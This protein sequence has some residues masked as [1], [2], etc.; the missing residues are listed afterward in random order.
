LKVGLGKF[1][2]KGT[3]SL[4][5]FCCFRQLVVIGSP[6]MPEFEPQPSDTQP[7]VM[8][9]QATATSNLLKPGSIMRRGEGGLQ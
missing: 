3:I 9:N 2:I 1:I 6:K 7:D 4:G 5:I 8:S